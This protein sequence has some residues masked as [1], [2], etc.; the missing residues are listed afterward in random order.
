[1]KSLPTDEKYTPNSIETYTG[2]IFDLKLMEPSTI[3]IEDIAHGLSHVCR[4]G[5]HLKKF[6]SVAQH[7][8][9]V[10]NQLGVPDKLSG[11]MHDASEAYLGDMPSPF[12]KMMP[13]YREIEYD[14]MMVISKKYD[15]QYPLE[16][17]IKAVDHAALI[18]EWNDH[19]VGFN[20]LECWS[21]EEAKDEFLKLFRILTVKAF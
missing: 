12:K 2:L 3:C 1:M 15:F 18:N 4:F 5:G 6:Y 9:W 21:P 8:V 17:Q 13:G 7:C 14:L 11:L 20:P 19:K 10:A 16:P